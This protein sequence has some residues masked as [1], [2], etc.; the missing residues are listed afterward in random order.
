MALTTVK[1]AVLNRGVNVKDYGAKGDGVTDDTAAIQAALDSGAGNVLFPSGSYS[2]SGTLTPVNNQALSLD[3]DVTITMNS[4]SVALMFDLGD[5]T[6]VRIEGN[7]ATLDGNKAVTPSGIM[8]DMDSAVDCYLSDLTINDSPSGGYGSIEVRG[9]AQRNT[10]NNL[11]GYRAEGSFIAVD[12]SITGETPKQTTVNNLFV[13]D[14]GA[15]GIRVGLAE[16][17]SI[18]NPRC[19]SNGIEMVGVTYSG[20]K[21]KVVNPDISGCGDN[22]ISFS[23]D[24]NS[25]VGGVLHDNQKAGIWCWGSNNR[26]VG[27]KAYNN[28]LEDAGNNWAGFGAS[29][30]YGG[31]GQDNIFT[32]C[33]ADDEQAVPTQFN[34]VRFASSTY[35]EWATA[36]VYASGT[37]VYYGLNI[38]LIVGSGTSGATP[39]THTSGDVSDG[40]VTWRYINTFV[41]QADSVRNIAEVNVIRSADASFYSH[42]LLNFNRFSTV[43]TTL[44]NEQSSVSVTGTTSETTLR[45]LQIP[46]NLIGPRGYLRVHIHGSFTGAAGNK[47]VKLK[48]GSSAAVSQ[49]WTG[50]TSWHFSGELSNTG[51]TGTQRTTGTLNRAS[52]GIMQSYTS[53][54]NQDTTTDLNLTVTGQLANAADTITSTAFTVEFCPAN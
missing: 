46:A 37:Y 7:G 9:T 33:V 8:I 25:C 26:V 54:I 36:T 24:D 43:P 16:D 31:A 29:A 13:E 5:K 21:V 39:P 51:S 35:S 10:L 15:F 42:N 48:L 1:G 34:G 47:T 38:Y 40:G 2:L 50:G 11:S 49:T 20:S 27:V 14:S 44:A 45:T 18:V 23:G 3:S 28:N 41:G 17:V 22:A 53:L 52:D 6:N 30:N 12:G 4:A 32:G 19:E